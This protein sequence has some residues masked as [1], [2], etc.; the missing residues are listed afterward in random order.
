MSGFFIFARLSADRKHR[1]SLPQHRRHILE[2]IVFRLK[3][4]KAGSNLA[5][6]KPMLLLVF[7]GSF[8]LRLAERTLLSLLFHEP[9]RSAPPASLHHRLAPENAFIVPGRIST[10][11][12]EVFPIQPVLPLQNDIGKYWS[13]SF[14]AT[15]G[16]IS[17]VSPIPHPPE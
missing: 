2:H 1:R 11:R 13:V 10:S 5:Q 7:V 17:A 16:R 12:P 15:C 8:L 14:V 4:I 3:I 9:P 6:R